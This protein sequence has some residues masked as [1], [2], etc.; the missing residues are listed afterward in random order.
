MNRET[1]IGHFLEL[2]EELSA[3]LCP[4]GHDFVA[5]DTRDA[6]RALGVTDAEIDEQLED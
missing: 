6:L 2:S 4:S 3:Q 5:E 1:A